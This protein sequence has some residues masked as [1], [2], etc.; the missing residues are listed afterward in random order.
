MAYGHVAGEGLD[1]IVVEDLRDQAHVAM[2][3]HRLPVG[4]GNARAFLAAVLQGKEASVSDVAGVAP[5]RV[6]G[7][8][9]TLVLGVVVDLAG[10]QHC[11]SIL[12]RLCVSRHRY[13]PGII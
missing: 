5:W 1:H 6:D 2:D 13:H 7:H 9:P 8:N 3:P 12:A 11:S 10:G 4:D